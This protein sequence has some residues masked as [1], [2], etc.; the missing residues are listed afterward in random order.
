MGG[1]RVTHHICPYC[2]TELDA[3]DNYKA[4]RTFSDMERP[5]TPFRIGMTGQLYGVDYTI[6]GSL[7]LKETWG[8]KT[9][10]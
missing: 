5:T 1:G 3:N 8:W 4:L 2:G 9:G 10:G 7:G 6:I